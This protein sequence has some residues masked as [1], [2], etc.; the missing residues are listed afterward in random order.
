MESFAFIIALLLIGIALQ[1]SSAPADFAKSL[2][3]FVIYVSLPATVLLQVP[4]IH[5]DISALGV[6]QTAKK[7]E[8]LRHR[9]LNSPLLK[10]LIMPARC[11]HGHYLLICLYIINIIK[12]NTIISCISSN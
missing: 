4:K 3:F 1:K 9:I 8:S 6:V 11:N 10:L 5:L 12:H 7:S 2:N